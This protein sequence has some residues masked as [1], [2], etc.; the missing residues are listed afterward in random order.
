M[1]HP[2]NF[3][4]LE[5][6]GTTVAHPFGI[7]LLLLCGVLLLVVP[8]RYAVW[9]I[10]LMT[11]FLSS[12][13]CF[14]VFGLNVYFT[15]VMVLCFGLAR[16]L[17]WSETRGF[18]LNALDGCV[19]AYGATYWIAGALNWGFDPVVLKTR[20]GAMVEMAA[21]YLFLRVLIREVAD[22][23]SIVL[24]IAAI[25]IP[26]AG[27]FLLE[28]LTGH[29]LFSVFGGVPE[30]TGI[31]EGRLRCQ[32]PFGHPIIAGVFWASFIPLLFY[33]LRTAIRPRLV[34]VA[35]LAGAGAIV[36]LSASSTP[37]LGAVV[38]IVGLMLFPL[39]RYSRH[40]LLAGLVL[41]ILLHFVMHGPV[42]SLIAKLSL[43][44]GS[45]GYHRFLLVDQFIGHY[46]EWWLMGSKVG[47]DHWGYGMFDTANQFVAVG[48]NAGVFVLAIYV[49]GIVIAL[50]MCA[51][52]QKKA[53]RLGW[54]LAV[55]IIV[56][57]VCFLGISIWAQLPFTWSLSLAAIGS[58]YGCVREPAVRKT[59]N[60]RV[61]RSCV[62][63][64]GISPTPEAPAC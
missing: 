27:F 37:A 56:Q 49:A 48:V 46:N 36:V 23:R 1:D 19:L 64:A 53:P 50:N 45:T 42:W 32:G 17:I 58:M 21:L 39:R 6:S 4:E 25:A 34:A 43:V 38:G 9:P 14:A 22:V 54:A 47:T 35:G 16:V 29:N 24:C 57:C 11:C 62:A 52:I 26:T 40:A 59:T 31:R 44:P 2:T 15:R 8:R 18:K 5:G 7:A 51:H 30:V 33:G 12:R 63:R 10:A 28:F 61:K 3:F 60:R 41:L 20:S 13:Q 55:T